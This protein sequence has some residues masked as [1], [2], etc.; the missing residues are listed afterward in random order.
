MDVME[1]QYKDVQG[2]EIKEDVV[3]LTDPKRMWKMKTTKIQRP[4]RYRGRT[5]LM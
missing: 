3:K 1:T 2:K 5:S 4:K